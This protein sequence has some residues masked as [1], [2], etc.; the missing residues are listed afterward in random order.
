MKDSKAR[1]DE[2]QQKAYA[3]WDKLNNQL[4][5][6][7]DHYEAYSAH[8][9]QTKENHSQSLKTLNNDYIQIKA[10]LGTLLKS[11]AQFEIKTVQ[12]EKIYGIAIRFNPEEVQQFTQASL[13][14]RLSDEQKLS[15]KIELLSKEL[16]EL[17]GRVQ[18]E[19]EQYSQASKEATTAFERYQNQFQEEDAIAGQ[20]IRELL[21]NLPEEMSVPDFLLAQKP[22]LEE[23]M[24]YWEQRKLQFR[25]DIAAIKQE[26]DLDVGTESSP[27]WVPNATIL[28]AKQKLE[29][30]GFAVMLGTEYVHHLE[31]AKRKEQLAQFPLLPYA[32]VVYK[33]ADVQDI[34]QA[35]VFQMMFTFL[36][37]LF[38]RQNVL[39]R[40]KSIYS[41]CLLTRLM[42]FRPFQVLGQHGNKP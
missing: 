24:Q 11:I 21:V 25:D 10:S 18:K 14:S 39:K 29:K 27:V 20:L 32:L 31:P 3:E 12:M 9:K 41:P 16:T 37:S 8:L 1:I 6:V 42:N 33:E 22:I 38:M 2:L 5:E 35:N 34:L 26:L 36:Q 7:Q 4:Q 40:T 15:A 19:E 28:L 23:K 30:K 17:F 13:N